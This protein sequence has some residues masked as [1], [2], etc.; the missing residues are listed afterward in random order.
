MR[1]SQWNTSHYMVMAEEHQSLHGD[2]VQTSHSPRKGPDCLWTLTTQQ[3]LH[4]C[5]NSNTV[6]FGL[7]SATSSPL[8]TQ[9]HISPYITSATSPRHV[10]TV[11]HHQAPYIHSATSS[12]LHTQCHITKPLTVTV[13]HQTP[14]IH[15]ATS[16]NPLH[17]HC[18]IKPLTYTV[19][20]QTPYI[21]CHIIK[22]LT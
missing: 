13:S 17:T 6:Y 4:G 22:P 20:H 12:P 9:C 5:H 19:P 14:Y 15:S 18:H 10:H 11:P 7:N 21:E 8:H 3:V 1:R 2:D 16:S